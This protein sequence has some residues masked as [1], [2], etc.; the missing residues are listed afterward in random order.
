LRIADASAPESANSLKFMVKVSGRAEAP[1]RVTYTTLSATAIQGTDF[2]AAKGQLS[3]Q[4]GKRKK[5]IVVK[6]IPDDLSEGK[7]TLSLRLSN[8]RAA[9]ISRARATGAIKDD[10]PPRSDALIADAA[11]P[12]PAAPRVVIN[13]L[14]PDPLGADL[15][16]EFIELLNASAGAVALD[17]WTIDSGSPCSLSGAIGPGATYVVSKDAQ[18]G[19]AACGASLTGSAGTVTLRDGP[20][21]S[22]TVIDTVGFAGFPVANGQSISLDPA[23][24][25][26]VANDLAASW[27]KAI[28][29]G[30]STYD[31][32]GNYGTPGVV[33]GPCKK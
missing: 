13:E 15:D 9:S 24:A 32:E 8:P 20:A 27:C 16:H 1:I 11:G 22:G 4:P 25:D 6:L 17:G 33:N 5:A 28:D 26:P 2:K 29:A 10:D 18:V 12:P 3:F 31:P 23:K 7:E 19:D 30:A 21:A 14:M